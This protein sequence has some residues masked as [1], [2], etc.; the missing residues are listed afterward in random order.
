MK[1]R[2][3]RYTSFIFFVMGWLVFF[4]VVEVFRKYESLTCFCVAMFPLSSQC[5]DDSCFVSRM[6]CSLP[7]FFLI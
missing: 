7:C 2:S 1:M 6:K 5:F 4:V 3:V